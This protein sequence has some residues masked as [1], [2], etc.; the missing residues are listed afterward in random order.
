M[1]QT[2]EAG[3][4]WCLSRFGGGLF[5]SLV[6]IGEALETRTFEQRLASLLER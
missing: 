2:E 5:F 3:E 1:S 6:E 4:V